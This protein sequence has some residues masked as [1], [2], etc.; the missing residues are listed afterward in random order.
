MPI[1]AY[2]CTNYNGVNNVPQGHGAAPLNYD[3]FDAVKSAGLKY[4]L[5][6]LIDRI[7]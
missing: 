2:Y 4:A 1:H 5:E 6:L 7:I 3:R